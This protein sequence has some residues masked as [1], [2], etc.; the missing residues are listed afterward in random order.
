MTTYPLPTLAATV[1][2]SGITA[3]AYVD[4]YASLQA[5]FQAIYGSDSYI[6]P[7]SQ[8]G[9]MLA[10]FARAIH[11]SN[12]AA[13]AAYNNFSP[14]TAQ[15][16]G[17]SYAVKINGISR[18][19]A[20]N[21]VAVVTITG[22]AGT[23]ISNGLIGD[24]QSLGTQWALQ[25]TVTIPPE[26]EVTT[27]AT[28]TT[29][30][31]VAAEADT[32]TRILNPQRGWQAV[33]NAAAASLGRAVESD[34]ALRQRQAQSTSLA[35]V[36]PLAALYG[37]IANA[38]GVTRLR[39]Y[40]ND[41]GTT[42]GNGIP[43][44]TVCAVVEGGAP[45]L[46]AQAI[47]VKKAPGT[48]TYGDTSVLVTDPSGV[49]V[50]I[51]YSTLAYTDIYATVTITPLAGYTSAIGGYIVA[52]LVQ[53]I[54]STTIGAPVT[55]GRLWSAANLTGTAAIAAV[56]AASGAA[57]T[58]AQLD[59]LSATYDVTAITVGTAPDPSGSA[60]VPVPFDSVAQTET[61]QIVLTVE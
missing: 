58:Q 14:A 27:A 60:N 51:R 23:V 40:E 28:C 7:D 53:E 21:S 56:S 48:G 42:D 52:A 35:A 33:T 26:G 25:A 4:I 19:G 45:A 3:P 11:D 10:I 30:G 1:S 5:S 49:P 24:D 47:A 57:Q 22:Q 6:A 31:A 12:S 13:I 54:N 59:A 8:D 32:L 44:H 43:G 9:Q 34:A 55:Y 37:Q 2:A 36:T 20:T 38:A 61:D 16:T 50:T 18:I 15:G 17:L 29:A 41:T 39:L 46:I